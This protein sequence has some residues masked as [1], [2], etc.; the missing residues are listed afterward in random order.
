VLAQGQDIIPIPGTRREQYLKDNIT[1]TEL[2]LD[3][4]ELAELSVLFAPG[5]VAGTR[6]DESGMKR[7]GI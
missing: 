7:V 6:Y 5:A 1:A 2:S 3:Q 4:A